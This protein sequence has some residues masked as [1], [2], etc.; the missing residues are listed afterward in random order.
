MLITTK[1]YKLKCDLCGRMLNVEADHVNDWRRKVPVV[2]GDDITYDMVDMCV[3]CFRRSISI[4][5]NADGTKYQ[6]FGGDNGD[7]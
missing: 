5:R 7:D 4:K 1:T 6:F 3:P 2:C